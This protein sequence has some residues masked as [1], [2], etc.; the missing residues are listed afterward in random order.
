M[1]G[2]TPRSRGVSICAAQFL[3]R[4]QLMSAMIDTS[5]ARATNTL[6]RRRK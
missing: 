1:L 5:H 4:G 3:R 6:T 2:N